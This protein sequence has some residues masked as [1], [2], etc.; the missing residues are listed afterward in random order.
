MY[1]R[2]FLCERIICSRDCVELCKFS[3]IIVIGNGDKII[4][5]YPKT[6]TIYSVTEKIYLLTNSNEIILP[7]FINWSKKEVK[8]YCTL[9]NIN[10]EING[11]GYVI[12]QSIEPNTK[13]TKEDKLTITLKNK[14]KE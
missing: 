7:N 11:N 5:T 1:K 4:S 14:I 10:C 12:E 13:L 9:A 3:D 6:N 2:A 8:T